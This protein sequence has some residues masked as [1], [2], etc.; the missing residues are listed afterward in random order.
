MKLLDGKQL[1]RQLRTGVTQAVERLRATGINPKL[2]IVVATRDEQTAWYVRSIEQAAQKV[3]I[4]TSVVQLEPSASTAD[5]AAA[6]RHLA[7]DPSVHGLMLQTPLPAQVD[8]RRLIGLIP[9]EKD[10]DGINPAS[11]GHLQCG[12][13]AFVPATAAAVLEL[14]KHYRVPLVGSRAVVVGRSR[15][16]GLPVA[17]LL[18]QADATVTI[19]HTRTAELAQE[20]RQ[21]DILVV[22]A[23]KPGLVG[24][25]SVKAGAVVID[26]GTNVDGA[27]K[28]VGD[29]EAEGFAE[30][31]VSLTPVPGGVGPVTTAILL[32]H[33]IDAV[34]RL[35]H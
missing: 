8:S 3:G 18:L 19:C 21:A 22:A 25:D 11:A 26:V 34:S 1:A 16:V 20:T 17:H 32:Q 33:V 13:P 10:V 14:L 24:A 27:G 30:K 2:A 7:A 12:L 15:V 4:E 6:L 28:L 31:D 35:S 23:G 9:L 29:V 5:I